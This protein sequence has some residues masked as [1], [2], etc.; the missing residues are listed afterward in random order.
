MLERL[1]EPELI[2][3]RLKLPW[4]KS[5]DLATVGLYSAVDTEADWHNQE[6]VRGAEMLQNSQVETEELGA[7]GWL[8]PFPASWRSG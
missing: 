2:R 4:H 7:L 1:R 5:R 6:M 3:M 8:P